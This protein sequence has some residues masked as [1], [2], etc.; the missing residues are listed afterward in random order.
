[1]KKLVLLRHGESTDDPRHPGRTD[2]GRWR[3]RAGGDDGA[4]VFLNLARSLV[5]R[6]NA[7]NLLLRKNACLPVDPAI[8]RNVAYLLL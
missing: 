5:V 3:R 4:S 2:R 7:P 8:L 6:I 1:M